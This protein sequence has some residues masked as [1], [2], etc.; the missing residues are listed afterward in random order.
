MIPHLRE[1]ERTQH[2]RQQ[3]AADADPQQQRS[4]FAKLLSDVAHAE[5]VG[6][7]CEELESE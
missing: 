5:N 3:P 6:V 1:F 2:P 4:M 7:R